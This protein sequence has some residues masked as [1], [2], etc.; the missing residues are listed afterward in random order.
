MSYY[1][2]ICSRE[3]VKELRHLRNVKYLH[4]STWLNRGMFL[5][6]MHLQFNSTVPKISQGYKTKYLL[7]QIPLNSDGLNQ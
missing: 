4:T 1:N 3:K 7:L 5:L 6:S 2:Y